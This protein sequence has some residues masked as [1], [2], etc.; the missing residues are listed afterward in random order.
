MAKRESRDRVAKRFNHLRRKTVDLGGSGK[1]SA[2][3]D[4]AL[5]GLSR[6]G[7]LR[8][9]APRLPWTERSELPYGNGITAYRMYADDPDPD[10]PTVRQAVKHSSMGPRAAAAYMNCCPETHLPPETYRRADQLIHCIKHGYKRPFDGPVAKSP[11]DPPALDESEKLAAVRL[12]KAGLTLHEAAAE[13]GC[14]ADQVHKAVQAAGASRGYGPRRTLKD[15]PKAIEL[16]QA[17]LSLA[18]VAKE[19]G[20]SRNSVMRALEE[21][22]VPRR[23]FRYE[24]KKKGGRSPLP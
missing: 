6:L 21:A 8:K 24:G 17:G 15:K 18:A 12:Y 9:P 13:L 10:S 11:V 4:P 3:V 19:L 22:G 2:P 23:P 16:Y 1:K 14:G 5:V 7:A 20:T